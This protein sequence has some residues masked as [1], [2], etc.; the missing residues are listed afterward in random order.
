MKEIRIDRFSIEQDSTH[1]P[2]QGGSKE[3][4]G[5]V[6]LQ[7]LV[8]PEESKE[9]ELLA[10]WFSAG[11]RTRA[12]THDT[13]QILHIVEGQGFVADEHE[14]RVVSMGD[15]VTVHAGQWHWHGAMPASS[16][17]HISVRKQ[18]SKTDWNVDPK[19]WAHGY[20][21]WRK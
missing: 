11:A 15:V 1:T 7:R 13:D 20:D 19:D 17:M 4:E 21:D 5:E 18:G 10:V 8:T 3:F 12:H 6:T 16:M 14:L 2:Y 9:V